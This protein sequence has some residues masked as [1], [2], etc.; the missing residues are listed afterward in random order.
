MAP[1]SVDCSTRYVEDVESNASA[2][3]RLASLGSGKKSVAPS[4]VIIPCAIDQPQVA[5]SEKIRFW[6]ASANSR[7]W[8]AALYW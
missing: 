2:S 3:T 8:G 4:P 5:S 7:F 6:L 1:V